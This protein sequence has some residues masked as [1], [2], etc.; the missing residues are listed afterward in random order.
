MAKDLKNKTE[1][2]LQKALNEAREEVRKFRFS[3]SGSGKKS[4]KEIRA[5]KT[6]IAQILTELRSREL[7]AENK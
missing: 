3:L 4:L 2:E 6:Q 7:S 1:K 5:T